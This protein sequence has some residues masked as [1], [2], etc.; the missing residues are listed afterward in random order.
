MAAVSPSSSPS[1]PSSSPSSPS[2]AASFRFGVAASGVRDSEE[3]VTVARRAEEL[4]YSSIAMADHLDDQLA[5]LITLTAVAAATTTLRVGTLVLANDYRHPAMLAKEAATLDLV[6]GGRLELGVGA[7]WMAVDYE[8]AGLVHDRPGVRIERLGEAVEIL[9]GLFG[10]E[11]YSFAGEHYT[12]SGLTGSP[13]PVQRPHPPLMI[14]GGGRKVLS[15]AARSADIVG[16][17]PALTAGVID[18][19]AGATATPSATERKVEWIR[20]AAGPRF[21]AIELQTRVH[22]AMI[23]DDRHGT[24]AALAPALGIS[25]EEAL[26]SPHA[27]VG[28][29]DECVE[30]VRRWRDRWG[31]SY[32]SIGAD[33]MEA[34]A[35]VVAQLAGT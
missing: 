17:N 25:T 16:L 9:K 31:I 8:Q 3:M 14:A 1:S 26:D 35:P 10:G 23:T 33:S 6:S 24:A 30:Q 34:M 22:L 2:S 20:E 4:G 28:T 29:V 21:D 15:L 32:I 27:L 5:P 18:E 13:T 12:I 7:G 19:R 11:P